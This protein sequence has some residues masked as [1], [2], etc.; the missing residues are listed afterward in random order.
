MEYAADYSRFGDARQM[1]H[2]GTAYRVT[3]KQQI[4]FH[5]GFG[6]SHAAPTRFF[7]AGYSFR[8]DRLFCAFR[9]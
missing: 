7:A 4:D 3:E 1:I 2:L 9:K 8:I 5:F 6:I